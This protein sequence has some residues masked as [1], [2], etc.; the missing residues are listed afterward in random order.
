M[1]AERHSVPAGLARAALPAAADP[2]SG[3]P[4]YERDALPAALRLAVGVVL[5]SPS[6]DPLPS[7]RIAVL[8]IV[9]HL[10]RHGI[11]PSILHDPPTAGETPELPLRLADEAV[12]RGLRVVVFQ[13][14]H[15]PS[16]LALVQALEARG[17]RTVYLVCDLVDAAMAAATSATAVVTDYLRSLYPAQLRPRIH[18]VHDGIERPERRCLEA[19][20]G[21]DGVRD[22]TRPLHAVLV[23][24]A[25]LTTLPVLGSP[26]RWLRVTIVGR[27]PPAGARR[28]RWRE[29][30]WTLARER[31]WRAR[32]AHLRFVLQPRIA[33]E[34]WDP[35][36]VYRHLES[37]DLGIIPIET[38]GADA[39]DPAAPW[40]VKSENR[41]TLKMAMG[42]PV[43]ATPIP[44]YEP[45]VR[46]GQNAFFAGTRAEWLDCLDALRDAATRRAIGRAARADVIER[47]S[48]EAQAARLAALLH[49]VAAATAPR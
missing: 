30:R 17:V 15:G 18:V 44:A 21:D 9:A 27:Y 14:V 6:A 40:R 48:Q 32:A 8:D 10:R 41:L 13:K 22:A 12:A 3:E 11:E 25:A 16:V 4:A 7:T 47:F 28:A 20:T 34:A 1:H 42:L 19:A 37:A 46:H 5:L 31:D 45:V 23:T 36:G 29:T 38:G 35:E 2:A 33:R 49:S 39:A 24:S 43:V 26:P